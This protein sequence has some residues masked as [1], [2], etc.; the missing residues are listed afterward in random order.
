MVDAKDNQA[1]AGGSEP[2]APA[3]LTSQIER[4]GEAKAH[5]PALQT[6][7]L[8][9]LGGAFVA[10]GAALYLVVVTE[11]GL[12]PGL[13]RWLGGFAF[14]LGLVMIVVGGAELFT[15]N[16]LM[17]MAWAARRIT[18][19]RLARNWGLV[20]LGNLAGALGTLLLLRLADFPAGAVAETAKGVAAAK[21]ALDPMVAFARGLLCNVFV[22]MAIWLALSARQTGGKILAVMLPIA[23]F[24][25]L[26]LE[27]SVAN[28]L[29]LPLG[30]ALSGAWDLGALAGNLG[31]VILGNVAGGAGLVGAAYWLIYRR[32]AAK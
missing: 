18:L 15:G 26:G 9:V 1:A 6:L 16:S 12:G 20:L 17:V 14:S 31:P 3:E 8:A 19:A 32:L 25:A 11:S 13:S 24:V 5:L 29:F 30:Q 21:F 7:A 4:S 28:F 22:C 10:L 2:Y 23:A 27:H